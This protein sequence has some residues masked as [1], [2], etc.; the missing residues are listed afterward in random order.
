MVD[1]E[2]KL[3]LKKRRLYF[4]EEKEDTKKTCYEEI[5]YPATPML[6]IA[7]LEFIN[8]TEFYK[9]SRRF[10]TPAERKH[11]F[12]NDYYILSEDYGDECYFS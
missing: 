8:P 12:T 7:D 6:S 2:R 3:P 5:C 4:I 11:Y 1:N 9:C 10:K